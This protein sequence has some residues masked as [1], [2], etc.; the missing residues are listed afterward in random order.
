MIRFRLIAYLIL[1][2]ILIS[3]CVGDGQVKTKTA[4]LSSGFVT[5]DGMLFR[6]QHQRELILNGINLIIKDSKRGYVCGLA[7]DEFKKIGDWGF[8]VIRLGIIWDG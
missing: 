2:V 3:S 1:S 8:N 5:V 6:D 4:K 7:E